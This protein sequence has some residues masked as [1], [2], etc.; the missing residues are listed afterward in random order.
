MCRSRAALVLL[1]AASL[2]VGL[3]IGPA[4]ATLDEPAP[5]APPLV[6]VLRLKG[7][8]QPASLRYLRRG[9]AEAARRGAEITLLELDTPGGLLVSLREMT[10]ALT[11]AGRPVVV[12][13]TPPGARAASAG[14]FL[15]LAADVAA[16]APGTS[17]GAAHPVTL[18]GGGDDGGDDGDKDKQDGDKKSRPG[19]TL[20]EK[21]TSDAAALARALAAQ[22][23][24]PIPAAEAAV[25]KSRSWS[26]QEAQAVGLIDL[27]AVDRG[28]LLEA[29][30]GRRVRRFDGREEI[31]HLASA[32]V[33][34]RN[35]TFTERLLMV[36][37][38][39]QIAYFLFLA[40]VLGLLLELLS[41]GMV[42]PGV[43]GAVCLL[44]ALYA[45]SILP[46]NVAGAL[47]IVVGL[48]LFA[49]EAFITSHGLLTAGGLIAFVLGSLIL[50]EPP[51]GMGGRLSPWLILP[52]AIVL[53][54]TAMLLLTKVVKTRRQPR[55]TGLD[56]LIG[57]EGE[58]ATPLDPAGR[59][60]VHGEFWEALAP[61]PLPPGAR[62]RIVGVA[63]RRLLVEWRPT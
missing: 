47:L 34:E 10:T 15:L 25:R 2:A 3:A 17:T 43:V 31:L 53:A 18:G 1:A 46:V 24:R 26:A 57:E 55:L 22:R 51:P 38:D 19:G 58:V 63:G 27:I 59:V 39:P 6:V 5:A 33:E 49:A 30:D 61:K 52:A 9:L 41:P 54:G 50:I 8:I 23:G 16:M 37:A 48:G 4:G 40:G 29:L 7:S 36:I 20:A 35:P 56:A 21:V 11:T 62:V 28:A 32:V 13:V 12:Y 42:V 60:F 44:L 14:F 45:F